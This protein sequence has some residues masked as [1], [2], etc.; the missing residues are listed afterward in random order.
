MG[1]QW[2]YEWTHTKLIDKCSHPSLYCCD[3]IVYVRDCVF[4]LVWATLHTLSSR[5][6]FDRN[7][8]QIT[9]KLVCNDCQFTYRFKFGKTATPQLGLW[10]PQP[11]TPQHHWVLIEVHVPDAH[12]ISWS[13]LFLD[14]AACSPFLSKSDEMEHP[15]PQPL[16]PH[17]QLCGLVP[18][19]RASKWSAVPWRRQ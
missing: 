12:T 5:F 2:I 13:L 3:F 10:L 14:V 4:N 7:I 1:M 16:C 8:I 19:G 18:V 9:R 11:P 15:S 6:W 17:G